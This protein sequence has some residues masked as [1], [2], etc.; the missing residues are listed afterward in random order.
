ML[1]LPRGGVPV[2]YEVARALHVALDVFVVRKLGLPGQPDFAMGAVAFG[3]IVVLDED[4]ITSMHVTPSAVERVITAER[5]ELTRR[6]RSYRGARPPLDV[7]G[8]SLI[9]VD[10]GLATG[11]SAQAAITALRRGRPASMVVASPVGS[12]QAC[13]AIAAVTDGCLCPVTPEPFYAVGVWYEDFRDA[14]EREV[15][16]LLAHG[17]S[18]SSTP[19]RTAAYS[20]RS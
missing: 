1:G 15:R 13:E 17:W 9:I 8:R 6:E 19:E 3:G 11:A 14:T 4:L 12:R 16:A 7:R 10:D 18:P 20:A 5:A 2:A